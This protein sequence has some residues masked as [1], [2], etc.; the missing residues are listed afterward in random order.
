MP[1]PGHSTVYALSAATGAGLWSFPTGGQ[2]FSSPAVAD[3]VVHA[4]SLD[5]NVYSFALAGGVA[6]V[7]GPAARQ[8][9]P[10]HTLRPQNG[11]Q[12]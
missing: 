6:A 8:L 11:Q 10:D 4:G 3:G 5:G 1:R 7:R 2:V 12:S 9:H